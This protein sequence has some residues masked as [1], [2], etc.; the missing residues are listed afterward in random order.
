MPNCLI[1]LGVQKSR[2]IE[3]LRLFVF[4]KSAIELITLL[5]DA[6]AGTKSRHEYWV[7]QLIT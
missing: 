5:R 7:H 4:L 2:R 6:D 3:L 1:S